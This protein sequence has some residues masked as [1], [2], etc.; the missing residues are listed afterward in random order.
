MA[1]DTRSDLIF[2][3]ENGLRVEEPV[4]KVR[5]PLRVSDCQRDVPDTLQL[6]HIDHLLARF[7]TGVGS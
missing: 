2:D 3:G 5:A 6:W 1:G 4:V 7:L